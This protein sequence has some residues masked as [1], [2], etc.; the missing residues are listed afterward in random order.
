MSG[1]ETEYGLKPRSSASAAA[2]RNTQT[3]IHGFGLA[4]MTTTARTA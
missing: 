3:S 2:C 1:Y 4:R